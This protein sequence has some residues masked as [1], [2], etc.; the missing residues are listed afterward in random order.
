MNTARY[1]SYRSVERQLASL[2]DVRLDAHTSELLRDMAEGLLL[3]RDGVRDDAD[4]LRGSAAVAL[5]ML[6]GG[7]R[8]TDAEAD[9]LW[10]RI[11]RC[12]PGGPVG[13]RPGA[14]ALPAGGQGVAGTGR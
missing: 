6:V 12:G 2:E 11:A 1:H 14:V 13:S 4:E 10:T 5:S 9:S 8:L 3:A 7:G